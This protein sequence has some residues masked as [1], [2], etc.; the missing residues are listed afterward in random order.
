MEELLQ[1]QEDGGAGL[2]NSITGSPVTYAGGGG[3]GHFYTPGPS[4]GTGG[5]GGGGPSLKVQQVVQQVLEQQ[6]QLI[7]EEEVVEVQEFLEI[8]RWSRR[9]RNRYCIKRTRIKSHQASGHCNV[10]TISRNRE[11]GHRVLNIS[12]RLFSSSRRWWRWIGASGGGGGAGGYRTSFPGGTKIN[13]RSWNIL[14]NNS[15]SRWSRN[16]FNPGVG[17]G[18]EE[19]VQIQFFQQLHQQVVVEQEVVLQVNLEDWSWR[20][21][22]RRWRI[23]LIQHQEEQEILHH[24]STTRK[25]RWSR[26]KMH[27]NRFRW[28]RWWSWCCGGVA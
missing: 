5:T 21:W 10:N 26:F 11:R 12:S 17:N 15:W 8:N 7:L 16:R 14:S 13:I 4:G 3:G 27:P 28:R 22:W 25:C 6:E 24:K 19:L 18:Q 20:I 9:I 2:S 23:F 1:L